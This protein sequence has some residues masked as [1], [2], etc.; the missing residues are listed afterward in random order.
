M[1]LSI[2]ITAIEARRSG[3][4]AV[5]TVEISSGGEHTEIRKL[6]VASKMLFEIGNIGMGSIPYALTP[7]QFDTLEYDASLWEAVKKGLDILSYGD[8]TKSALCVK[9]RQRGFGRFISE[10]AAEYIAELGYINEVQILERTVEQLADVKLY[11]PS[12]IKNEIYKKGISR[13]IVAEHLE[14]CLEKID[15]EENLLKLVRKK[16]DCDAILERDYREKFYAAMYRLGYSPN[17]TRD[18][19]KT[20]REENEE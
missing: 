17:Q 9:L 14:D 10:D 18:A 2:V 4:E 1:E 3:D 20:I 11:G 13:E 7:E 12:R 16:C 19:I 5:L 8:N 15:F 6:S